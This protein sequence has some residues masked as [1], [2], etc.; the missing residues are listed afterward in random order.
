MASYY[1]GDGSD[2]ALSAGV[3]EHATRSGLTANAASAQKVVTVASTTGFVAGDLIFFHQTRGTGVGNYEFN[4]ID[5]V[6][7]ATQLT[8]RGNLVNS[9]TSATTG[10]SKAQVLKIKQYSSVNLTS[11]TWNAPAWDGTTGGILAAVSQG[12]ITINGGTINLN[13]LGF[14]ASGAGGSGEGTANAVNQAACG[15]NGNGGGG[16]NKGTTV[17]GGASGA[18]GGHGSAGGAGTARNAGGGAVTCAGTGGNAVGLA[19]LENG[20]FNLGGGGGG[21]DTTQSFIVRAGAKGAGSVFLVAGGNITFTAG[22]ISANGN[23]GGSTGALTDGGGGGAAGAM[24]F[25][26]Q[27]TLALGTGL[28]TATGGAGATTGGGADGG[29]GAVGRIATLSG[30]T[31]TGTS[32]P[33]I[34]A[35]STDTTTTVDPWAPPSKHHFKLLMGVASFLFAIFLKFIR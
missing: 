12:A 32:N 30:A 20:G 17:S 3:T 34:N 5:S 24:R 31:V 29:G 11:G 13:G 23:S 27:G 2:G 15:A 4:R 8:L 14:D 26:T 35:T 22:A 16:G 10:A 33:A 9:Y 28:A 18:G 25:V 1:V 6:D 21:A 7:S 19:T